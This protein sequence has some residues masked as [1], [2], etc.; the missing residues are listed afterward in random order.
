MELHMA[1]YKKLLDQVDA[2]KE[3]L[4]AELALFMAAA[5][6]KETLVHVLAYFATERDRFINE[7]GEEDSQVGGRVM[8]SPAVLRVL[9]QMESASLLE[10]MAAAKEKETECIAASREYKALE[11]RIK[12]ALIQ[13]K[14]LRKKAPSHPSQ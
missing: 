13:L 10:I 3:A 7:G 14:P 4:Q 12:P 8:E 11:R 1:S 6:A 2:R 9:V 5:V